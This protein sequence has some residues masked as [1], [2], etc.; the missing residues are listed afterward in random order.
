MFG[1]WKKMESLN[2]AFLTLNDKH[3]SLDKKTEWVIST[4]ESLRVLPYTFSHKCIIKLSD[5]KKSI[6]K[7]TQTQQDIMDFLGIEYEDR[8]KPPKIIKKVKDKEEK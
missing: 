8:S 1:F 7:I 3:N 4:L 5:L 6:E 2:K